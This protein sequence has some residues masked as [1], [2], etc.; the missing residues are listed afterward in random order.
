MEIKTFAT[1]FFS[2]WIPICLATLIGCSSHQ[3]IED[4]DVNIADIKSSLV[5]FFKGKIS[6]KPSESRT[7]VSEPFRPRLLGG[8]VES[9]RED[10][11]VRVYSEITIVGNEKPYSLQVVVFA[12]EITKSGVW[13]D[14]GE[15]VRLAKELSQALSEYLQKNRN[16]NFIDHFRAF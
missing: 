14:R 11:E 16:K 4:V 2:I 5:S 1:T 9:L 3:T 8:R 15:N 7:L 10:D 13:S 6:T 12:Q